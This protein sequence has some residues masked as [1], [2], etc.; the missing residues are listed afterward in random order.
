MNGNVP[1]KNNPKPSL[2][3]GK[4]RFNP[5]FWVYI[6]LIAIII[7][8]MF[9][10]RSGDPVKTEWITVKEQMGPGFEIEEIKSPG[11][12]RNFTLLYLT[13]LTLKHNLNS[14]VIHFRRNNVLK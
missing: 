6:I 14:C 4:K 9:S 12:L 8:F 7:F 2:P 5:F 13:A 10:N 1:N 3:P 11:L